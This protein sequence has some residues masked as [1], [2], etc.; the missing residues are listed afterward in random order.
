MMNNGKKF[1]MAVYC[2]A[3]DGIDPIYREMAEKLGKLMAAEKIGLVYGG[4][5]T[6]LMGT[7]ARSVLENGGSGIGITTELISKR[8]PVLAGMPTE[9]KE[10]LLKRKARMIELSDAFCILPGGMGT[11]NE[12]TDIMTMHQIGETNL[13]IYFLNTNGYWNRFGAVLNHM[14]SQGFIGSQTEYNMTICDTP[15][16]IIKAYKSRFF[17]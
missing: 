1:A 4:G 10:D 12:V 8:E 7:V 5:D 11:M 17:E 9:V 15:E 3:R 6:G 2:G 13:P 16:D 14:V